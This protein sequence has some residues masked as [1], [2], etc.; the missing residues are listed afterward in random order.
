MTATCSR[1]VRS[2]RACAK[3]NLRQA[4]DAKLAGR[5]RLSAYHLSVARQCRADANALR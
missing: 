3:L 5:P 1:A 4:K 2:L